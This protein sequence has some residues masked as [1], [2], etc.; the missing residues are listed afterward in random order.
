MIEDNRWPVFRSIHA[1]YDSQ[2]VD[3]DPNRLVPIDALRALAEEGAIGKLHDYVYV[4]TGTGTT[5]T[6]AERMGA[7]IARRLRADGVQA[8]VATST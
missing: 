7:E 1:G 5:V 3:A 8:V 4:T 2:W 6:D